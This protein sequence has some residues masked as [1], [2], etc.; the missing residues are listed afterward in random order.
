LDLSE[1]P[2]LGYALQWFSFVA[3]LGIGYPFFIRRQERRSLQA[4]EAHSDMQLVLQRKVEQS[5]AG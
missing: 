1:G 2:H 3:L 5:Q 4:A